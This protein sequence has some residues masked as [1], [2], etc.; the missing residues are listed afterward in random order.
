MVEFFQEMERESKKSMT[1][2]E[3][4]ELLKRLSAKWGV[5]HSPDMT[6]VKDVQRFDAMP[7]HDNQLK[8]LE[9]LVQSTE[10]CNPDRAN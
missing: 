10:S 7:S 8:R 5:P 3:S 9:E 1:P 6:F 4:D 2:K